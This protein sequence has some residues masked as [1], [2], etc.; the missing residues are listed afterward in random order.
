MRFEEVLADLEGRQP[1]RM[2]PDLDR[3]RALTELLDH[4]EL[5]Y[6]T[7]HVTGTNG[8]TTTA[9]LAARILCAQGLTAA[10]SCFG[11]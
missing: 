7:I 9:R 8:K 11:D 5:T 4:P 2:V 3:I 6:R 1:E 10:A